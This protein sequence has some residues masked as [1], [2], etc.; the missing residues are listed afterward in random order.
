MYV[1]EILKQLKKH[2]QRN[3]DLKAGCYTSVALYTFN[4]LLQCDLVQYSCLG[5]FEKALDVFLEM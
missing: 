1:P 4:R 3:I 2:F 5:H